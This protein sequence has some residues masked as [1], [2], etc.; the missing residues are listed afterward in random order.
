MEN[1]TPS[2][3]AVT[4]QVTQPATQN[5]QPETVVR[6]FV[7][8]G[9]TY[10]EVVKNSQM[11]KTIAIRLSESIFT[12]PHFYLTVEIA[13]DEAMKSRA[14]INNIPDTKVSFND[15]V[16]KACAMALKDIQK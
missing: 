12:A 10:T 2:A 4:S 15:M 9:E 14:A 11:R 5:S 7:P 13:M 3:S 6:P 8:A 1:F 16:I